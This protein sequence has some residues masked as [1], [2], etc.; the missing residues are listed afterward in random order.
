MT[1]YYES[2]YNLKVYTL[3][4]SYPEKINNTIKHNLN[5]EAFWGGEIYA[6]NKQSFIRLASTLSTLNF[7]INISSLSGN[8]E[9]I[10]VDT[11]K[12]FYPERS[13][14]ISALRSYDF[15]MLALDWPDESKVS[16]AELSTIFPTK[17]I[18]YLASGTPIILHCPEEYYLSRFFK[19]NNCGT[20]IN[21]RKT[22]E[23]KMII[24]EVL[25]SGE[26]IRIRQINAVK[27]AEEFGISKIQE[28]FDKILVSDG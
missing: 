12:R 6:I 9:Y 20:V 3:E 28:K 18:E 17:T 7:R 15:L 16:V 21:S 19:K 2:K 13:S 11:C 1:E 5:K 4:H 24:Q 27:I 25:S 8:S 26:H 10:G 22:D 14:Y 23:M